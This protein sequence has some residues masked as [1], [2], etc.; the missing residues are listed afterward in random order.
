MQKKTIGWILTLVCIIGIVSANINIQTNLEHARQVIKQIFITNNGLSPTPENTIISINWDNQWTLYIKNNLHTEWSV[1]FM[2]LEQNN[3]TETILS[4]QTDGTLTKTNINNLQNNNNNQGTSQ[5]EETEQSL[6]TNKIVG[7]NNIWS[8]HQFWV[9]WNS[10]FQSWWNSI[11][12]YPNNQYSS[13][14]WWLASRNNNLK[15]NTK[16]WWLLYINKDISASTIIHGWVSI[17][18]WHTPNA[19]L[20]ISWEQGY[21]QLILRNSYTPIDSQDSNWNIW[22][23]TWWEDWGKYYIYIKT[24]DWRYKASMIPVSDEWLITY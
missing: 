13:N 21:E 12:I 8:N 20:D 15:I 18:N 6:Q 7:I 1:K 11:Y 22:S 14:N 2:W 17:G 23:I 3:N 10:I 19:M 16:T 24:P 5:R 4:I 9:W